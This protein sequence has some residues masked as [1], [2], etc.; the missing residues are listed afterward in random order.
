MARRRV[1]VVLPLGAMF[2]AGV[3]N[4]DSLLGFTGYKLVVVTAAQSA[5]FVGVLV[6]KARRRWATWTDLE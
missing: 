2:A 1:H 4:P 6:K 5:L 3:D